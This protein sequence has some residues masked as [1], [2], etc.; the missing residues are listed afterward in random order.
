LPTVSEKSLRKANF[1]TYFRIEGSG[2]NL[3]LLKN[4]DPLMKVAEVG[5]S[6][7]FLFAS[8]ADLDWNDLPLNAAFLPLIQGL[9]K[10]AVGLTGT[11]LPPGILF[12][13]PFSEEGNPV[14]V[15]GPR[16]GPGIFQFRLPAGERRLGK[17]TPPEESD[18]TK[19]GE[20][21]LKKK[22]GTIEVMVREYEEGSL[23][24]IKGGQ[25]S[26]W[27]LL[28]VVLMALL[29]FEMIVANGLLRPKG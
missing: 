25:K 1:H 28:L 17:N 13:E 21:A 4:Q 11:S 6:R 20:D 15:S 2:K 23:E 10:E 9:L 26:L 8:S 19:I 14:Q 3:L 24:E 29:A 22:F 12:G 5:K 16:G 7:L 27:P 18:L